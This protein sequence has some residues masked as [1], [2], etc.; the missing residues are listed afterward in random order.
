M[1]I[2]HTQFY[3][4][5]RAVIRF[6]RLVVPLCQVR[7]VVVDSIALPFR[8]DFDDIPTRNRLLVGL[9]QGLLRLADRQRAAVSCGRSPRPN[10]N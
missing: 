5:D 8:Y 9:S 4:G 6:I 1:F 10:I 7:L 3:Y 2:A